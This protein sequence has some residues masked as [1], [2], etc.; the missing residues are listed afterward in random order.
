MNAA[1]ALMFAVFGTAMELLPRVFPGWF[2][3]PADNCAAARALWLSVM[4]AVQ[5]GLG[6][7]WIFRMHLVPLSAR[8]LSSAPAGDSEAIA[9]S[10]SHGVAG[11]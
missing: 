7:G 8:M 5:I 2:A 1:N 6:L 9:L 3:H 11:R 4:G 10:K